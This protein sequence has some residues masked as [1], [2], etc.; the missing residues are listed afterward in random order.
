ML[1]DPQRHKPR[2]PIPTLKPPV[3]AARGPTLG[4]VGRMF[5]FRTLPRPTDAAAALPGRTSGVLPEGTQHA[6][7]GIDLTRVPEG[8]QIASFALGCFWGAERLFWSTPGVLNTATG[9]QGGFTPNPTYEETCTGLTGHAEAV[10]VVFDPSH[11]TYTDLLRLFLENHDPTQHNRQGNDVGSQYRSALFP[12]DAPQRMAAATTI[13]S[14][15]GMLTDA[16]YG[17]I[18]TEIVDSSTFYYAEPHHQ[19]YLSKNPDGYCPIHATGVRC[20]AT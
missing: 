7:F 14:Y 5:G 2:R 19:Q 8:A 3:D 4:T 11:L 12:V 15:Q 6:V 16:G 9:Y 1:G 13:A 17:Q 10:R 18:A 20:T